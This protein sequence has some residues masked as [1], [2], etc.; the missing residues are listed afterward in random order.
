MREVTPETV[1]VHYFGW[2]SKWDTDLPRREGINAK[3]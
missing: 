2:G 1:K 3:V